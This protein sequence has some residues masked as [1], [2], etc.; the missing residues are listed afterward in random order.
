MWFFTLNY[1][2]GPGYFEHERKGGG[3]LN[4][5]GQNYMDPRFRQ[6]SMIPKEEETHAGEDVGVYAKGPYSHVSLVF[7]RRNSQ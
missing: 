4:P 5:R 2:N 6:P 1:A 7:H 3:R